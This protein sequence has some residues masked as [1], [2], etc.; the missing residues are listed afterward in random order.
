[1]MMSAGKLAVAATWSREGVE[2]LKPMAAASLWG[3][4]KGEGEKREPPLRASLSI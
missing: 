2:T 4:G 3:D 1:M